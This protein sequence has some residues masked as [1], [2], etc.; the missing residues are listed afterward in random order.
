MCISW[1]GAAALKRQW[2]GQAPARA[3]QEAARKRLY[4]K[5]TSPSSTPKGGVTR[6]LFRSCN[7]HTTYTNIYKR[8]LS[9]SL[10]LTH[11]PTHTHTHTHRP[12]LDLATVDV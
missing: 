1:D 8:T 9:L 7:E 4:F 11:K 12:F 6:R 3:P 5:F 2:R 10:S